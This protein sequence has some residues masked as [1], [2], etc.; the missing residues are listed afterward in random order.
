MLTL[1]R[2]RAAETPIYDGEQLLV[3]ICLDPP[4]EVTWP[5]VEIFLA[6]RVAIGIEFLAYVPEVV[7]YTV[8][9]YSIVDK[10][11]VDCVALIILANEEFDYFYISCYCDSVSA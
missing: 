1:E 3:R 5:L 2:R 8:E 6:P 9:D 10:M 11:P 7:P 4:F